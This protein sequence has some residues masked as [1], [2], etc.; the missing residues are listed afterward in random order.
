MPQEGRA[1]K[2]TPQTPV[3]ARAGFGHSGTPSALRPSS[4]TQRPKHSQ[5]WPFRSLSGPP[6]LTRAIS[7][8]RSAKRPSLRHSRLPAA[9]PAS[10]RL[11]AGKRGRP[12]PPHKL[13]LRRRRPTHPSPWPGQPHNAVSHLSEPRPPPPS[14]PRAGARTRGPG[15]A[16]CCAR[17]EEG[18]ARRAGARGWARGPRRAPG[19]R[20]RAGRREAWDARVRVERTVT[21][22]SEDGKTTRA[23]R[24]TAHSGRAAGR[25]GPAGPGGPASRR[26]L[27]AAHLCPP[28][29]SDESPPGVG[30]VGERAGRAQVPLPHPWAPADALPPPQV[31]A[32]PGAA[33][34]CF[35]LRWRVGCGKD[36]GLV[37]ACRALWWPQRRFENTETFFYRRENDSETLKKWSPEERG[38]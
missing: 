2:S 13:C 23:R 21:R 26:R 29:L 22:C 14:Q 16:P 6:L 17:A 32:P 5:T 1:S 24:R 20:W 35:L 18:D 38:G 15:G 10:S 3:P 25:S 19:A 4:H 31:C 36:N 27:G 28:L 34:W 9:S 37:T 8:E 12:P 7:L 33:T 11:Q 30:G